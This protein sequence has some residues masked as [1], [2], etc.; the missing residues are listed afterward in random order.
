[1]IQENDIVQVRPDLSPYG[2]CLVV[3]TDVNENGILG[4]IQSAGVKGQQY[5]LLKNEDFNPT[6]GKAVWVVS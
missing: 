6:G 2:G 4:Y 1:M 5:A 3:V